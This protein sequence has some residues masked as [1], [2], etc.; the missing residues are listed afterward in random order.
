MRSNINGTLHVVRMRKRRSR[1]FITDSLLAIA[2]DGGAIKRR[3]YPP[4]YYITTDRMR[5]EIGHFIYKFRGQPKALDKTMGGYAVTVR[6]TVEEWPNGGGA[7][8]TRP[9]IIEVREE[10]E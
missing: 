9:V 7:W 4:D 10:Q 3:E 6:A 1:D 5:S 2:E 8:L